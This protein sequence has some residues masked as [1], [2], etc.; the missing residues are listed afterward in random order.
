MGS[1]LG[2]PPK[3]AKATEKTDN[4]HSTP[5]KLAE[6][7]LALQ[8]FLDAGLGES[9]DS[10]EDLGEGTSNQSVMAKTKSPCKK[11]KGEKEVW[12]GRQCQVGCECLRKN[13]P[14][15]RDS[16]NDPNFHGTMVLICKLEC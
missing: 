11:K 10:E 13:P 5:T 14:E 2:T 1:P 12:T 8:A 6:R 15:L 3:T 16:C 4:P 7:R 9:S